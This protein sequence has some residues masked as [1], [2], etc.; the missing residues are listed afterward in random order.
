MVCPCAAALALMLAITSSSSLCLISKPLPLAMAWSG[1]SEA[2]AA[3]GLAFVPVA[4][5]FV[6]ASAALE[7]VAVAAGIMPSEVTAF[8]RG[9]DNNAAASAAEKIRFI[10]SF[11]FVWSCFGSIGFNHLQIYHFNVADV[12]VF[13]QFIQD[14]LR[15]RAVQAQ[16]RERAAARRVAPQAH[17][18]DVDLVPAEQRAKIADDARLVRVVQKQQCS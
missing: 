15:R 14:R 7:L 9:S 6:A 13:L 18:G 1:K 4:A 17:A 16:H 3:S 12:I 8:A 2:I 11:M 10:L 5:E